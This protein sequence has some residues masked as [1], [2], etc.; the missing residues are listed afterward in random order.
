M[1]AGA[2]AGEEAGAGDGG[3][4]REEGDGDGEVDGGGGA[5]GIMSPTGS[6]PPVVDCES[7]REGGG[8]AGGSRA[9]R[10][11]LG[12]GML[13]PCVPGGGARSGW[14][15]DVPVVPELELFTTRRTHTIKTRAMP[16]PMHTMRLRFSSFF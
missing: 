11:P 16:P 2:G 6:P 3:C 8:G 13:M 1:G 4:G 10:G 9:F 5:G 7:L 14:E 15:G 12:G